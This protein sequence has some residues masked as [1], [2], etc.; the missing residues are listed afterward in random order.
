MFQKKVGPK[1]VPAIVHHRL[2]D[3]YR[4][5][6]PSRFFSSRET[7]LSVTEERGK[8]LTDLLVFT[9][10]TET[11][12]RRR[13]RRR[14]TT[15]ERADTEES[16]LTATFTHGIARWTAPSHRSLSFPTYPAAVARPFATIHGETTGGDEQPSMAAAM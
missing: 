16:V 2:M 5:H 7:S 8:P 10:S 14:R 3:Y 13:R 12:G 1:T 15:G 6:W 11:Y 4:Q 9:R